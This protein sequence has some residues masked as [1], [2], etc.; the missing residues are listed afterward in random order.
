MFPRLLTS[1]AGPLIRHGLTMLSGALAAS[2]LPGLSDGTVG[3]ITEV[4]L[5]AVTLGLA[6]AWSYAEKATR[7]KKK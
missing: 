2:G 6:L 4:V 3:N 1:S 7:P 5:S